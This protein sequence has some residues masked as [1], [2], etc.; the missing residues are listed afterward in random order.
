M[1]MSN[2]LFSS[3]VLGT[4]YVSQ[5]PENH[6]LRPLEVTDY[7]KGFMDCL[8]NLTVT[9]QVSEQMFQESFEEM[10]RTGCY[11]IIVVEDLSTEK[12]VA[13]GCLMV[14]QKFIRECGRVGHIEDIVVAKGQ[15]GKRFG[16]TIVK[17]L[18]EIAN[19]TGCY[20]TILD[21]SKEN[22]AFYEKCGMEEKGVQM[23]LYAPNAAHK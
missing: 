19:V 2:S 12:I 6:V 17:Q 22:V 20:K 23:S 18:Q 16:K 8:S 5:V 13:S 3:S 15:Q 14:E 4:S 10:Q 7:R 1:V 9:G 11:F 21:C